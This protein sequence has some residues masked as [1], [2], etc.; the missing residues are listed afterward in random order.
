MLKRG[1]ISRSAS[2]VT[3]VSA[4][5]LL[6]SI[7]GVTAGT[8]DD[9]VGNA[10]QSPS[11]LVFSSA[12]A[13]GFSYS[14]WLENQGTV[15]ASADSA[16][17]D[18]SQADQGQAP[19]TYGSFV[20]TETPLERIY[21]NVKD[22][23]T[24]TFSNI[25][26][27]AGDTSMLRGWAMDYVTG[28]DVDI[29]AG[30][31]SWWNQRQADTTG[32]FVG[33][34][35]VLTDNIFQAGEDQVGGLSFIRSLDW[36]YQTELGGRPWQLGVNA[37][38]SL[39][40]ADDDVMLWQLRGFTAKDSK[41]GANA[42]LIYRWAQE[43]TA[44]F[45][46]NTFLD[47]EAHDLGDF[48]RWSVGGEVRTEWV[49]LY[50]N[51]YMA[52]TDPILQSDKTYAYTKDG[53]DLEAAFHVPN[54][55]WV[56]GY[57]KYYLFEGKGKD[58]E[59][60]LNNPDDKG[61]VY[62]VRV[63]PPMAENLRLELELDDQDGGDL[64]IGG[65]VSYRHEFGGIPA[66]TRAAS[67]DS[68][69]DPR[70]YFFDAVRRE[71]AQRIGI[72][73]AIGPVATIPAH[74]PGARMILSNFSET[75]TVDINNSGYTFSRENP[76]TIAVSETGNNLVGMDIA[77]ISESNY[78]ISLSDQ[79]RISFEE[80]GEIVSL[81]IGELYIDRESGTPD[82]IHTASGVRVSLI[83]TEMRIAYVE[84]V[85]TAITLYEGAISLAYDDSV[86]VSA[87]LNV[88]VEGNA[89]VH[90]ENLT[91]YAC[92]SGDQSGNFIAVTNIAEDCALTVDITPDPTDG[93][94]IVPVSVAN[95]EVISFY[96]SQGVGD[97]DLQINDPSEQFEKVENTVSKNFYIS[98]PK[99]SEDLD[100]NRYTITWT[101]E[102]EREGVY[103]LT[104]S[105]A[106]TV[107]FTKAPVTEDE[108]RYVVD[109]QLYSDTITVEVIGQERPGYSAGYT[110]ALANGTPDGYTLSAA[111]GFT[112]TLHA[113]SVDVPADG[114]YVTVS[115]HDS[116]NQSGTFVLEVSVVSSLTFTPVSVKTA[117]EGIEEVI[118]L[119][120]YAEGGNIENE[121][122][123]SQLW[124]EVDPAKDGFSVRVNIDGYDSSMLIVDA[125][126]AAGVYT[127]S[128]VVGETN[129]V[130]EGQGVITI[131]VA[132]A[133]VASGPKTAVVPVELTVEVGKIDPF[134]G[135]GDYTFAV[136]S[137]DS[138][139]E[140]GEKYLFIG[141][142]GAITVIN[143]PEAYG[144]IGSERLFT[145]VWSLN[146]G[147]DRSPEVRGTVS[148]FFTKAPSA[149]NAVRYNVAGDNYNDS[150]SVVVI[151]GVPAPTIGYT[152]A[153][154][155][156]TPDEYSLEATTGGT[157]TLNAV[158]ASVPATGQFVTVSI[159]DS[160][161]PPQ[162][163]TFVLEVIEVSVLTF[164]PDS[165][166]S[167]IEGRAEVIDLT[168]YAKGG[169]I[170]NADAKSDLSFM[171]GSSAPNGFNVGAD[172]M[173]TVAADVSPDVYTIPIIVSETNPVHEGTGAIV[174]T[175]TGSL[176]A[177]GLTE[178]I[179]PVE[180]ETQ[181]G[182]ITPTGGIGDYTF[183]LTG[184][185]DFTINS[186]L[187]MISVNNAPEEEDGKS[188]I[189]VWT[190]NDGDSRSP[191]VTGEVSVKFTKAPSA[192]NA[193]RYAIDGVAYNQTISIPVVGGIT[194]NAG[195]Y[196]FALASGTDSSSYSLGGTSGTVIVLNV[197]ITT[198]VEGVSFVTV[199]IQDGQAN[200]QSGTFVLEVRV[201]PALAFADLVLTITQT[202]SESVAEHV[203]GGNTAY[204]E[205]NQRTFSLGGAPN[206][207]TI[208]D[209]GVLNVGGNV[210]YGG[211]TITIN[212][213]DSQPSQTAASNVDLS[214]AFQPQPVSVDTSGFP[215]LPLD[216][217]AQLPYSVTLTPSGGSLNPTYTLSI[218]DAP[219][220]VS[221]IGGHVVITTGP[222]AGDTATFKIIVDDTA[223]EY[224]EGAVTAEI[225]IDFE[226]AKARY[227]IP[228]GVD[229]EVS[230]GASAV[231]PVSGEA[232][233]FQFDPKTDD[234][235]VLKVTGGDLTVTFFEWNLVI[236][237]GNVM[238]FINAYAIRPSN[239]PEFDAGFGDLGSLF[240]QE[241]SWPIDSGSE[242]LK[243]GASGIALYGG[244]SGSEDGLVGKQAF[245]GP[246]LSNFSPTETAA[247]LVVI[248]CVY[249]NLPTGEEYKC[250]GHQ[251]GIASTPA[252]PASPSFA[253]TTRS[254]QS[255]K[256]LAVRTLSEVASGTLVTVA[257]AGN[258]NLYRITDL[259][260][261]AEGIVIN[262]EYF[263]VNQGFDLSLP[264]EYY[265]SVIFQEQYGFIPYGARPASEPFVDENGENPDFLSAGF[266]AGGYWVF[267]ADGES[268]LY[269]T[270][271]LAL[272]GVDD[273][274]NS[275]PVPDGCTV[276]L[277]ANAEC[278]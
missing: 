2:V 82:R 186:S 63:S 261:A 221:I 66:G 154:A 141:D 94:V 25:I 103:A 146:D 185:D 158:N 73:G 106:I 39:R 24:Q 278:S 218:A 175:V 216:P 142:N 48:L 242:V 150:V 107:E 255:V 47:F 100:G 16:S 104:L 276:T 123:L 265:E 245:I 72:Y 37:I 129:P 182:V 178:A 36:D 202:F 220:Y 193:L 271:G 130:H 152:F 9:S 262:I 222:S 153:L 264:K 263:V 102:D 176:S 228:S 230:E 187:G 224:N 199:S 133:L 105:G 1:F 6:S 52:I 101:L 138:I 137:D 3:L 20:L 161:N 22:S 43:D 246:L 206:G 96:V 58:P 140:N 41:G 113:N 54:M 190:L 120:P 45:G 205:Y 53:L 249:A 87:S 135:I 177:S 62:G 134:G 15:P 85:E 160:Q 111:I 55:R 213:A 4:L 248:M 166:T 156:G 75:V 250:G 274:G 270:A 151:G 109:G 188:Y 56:S 258:Y 251:D 57:I 174:I 168:P 127:V 35:D 252:F 214:V 179:V 128:I 159:H 268:D 171:V 237:D 108:V 89:Q 92:N 254:T 139:G 28:Q 67:T 235:V 59:T 163:G 69:F 93:V 256:P 208:D 273:D 99:V 233:T 236:G 164:A 272:E 211:Y 144:E 195:N 238:Q 34:A 194:D 266:S 116:Q 21:G 49:D 65:R 191:E 79:T 17:T 253:K 267:T 145:L 234:G 162:S 80:D 126:V 257:E 110:F 227:T 74:A 275:A 29:Q 239:L 170:G 247:G 12:S 172:N 122:A 83:G 209:D 212:V 32:I 215:T 125:A 112:I 229:V 26:T 19:I 91:Y 223:T 197:G 207:L 147:D 7:S 167:A 10:Q 71:Y 38:G 210:P 181:V 30:I 118:D 14:R 95:P 97:Y 23:W 217:N 200:P 33:M 204:A 260:R 149:E 131:S 173:L 244:S 77:G 44:M 31:D 42:G 240:S 243:W 269:V 81:F 40:E 225:N 155:D 98:V 198:P 148:G 114:Q 90:Y 121:D 132:D 192:E 13:D 84:D 157:I 70:D 165:A 50:G 46:V 88:K 189:L 184:H 124:F 277:P 231:T 136:V 201:V 8:I 11:S 5:A 259:S 119:T 226:A 64:D 183:A 68:S 61:F 76:I 78:D 232:G 51:R 60:R 115:I 203:T 27:R 219:S 180:L 196:T 86:V 117:I 169:N 241:Q 143:A 18:E